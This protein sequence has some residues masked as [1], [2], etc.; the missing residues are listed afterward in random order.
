M[1]ASWRQERELRL[2]AE[3][4]EAEL[5]LQDATPDELADARRHYRQALRSFTGLVMDGIED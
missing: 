4:D 1:F 5:Q 3:L 2:K